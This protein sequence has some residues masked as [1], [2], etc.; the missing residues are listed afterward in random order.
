MTTAEQA[1]ARARLAARHAKVGARMGVVPTSEADPA[2]VL[3]T[4]LRG[5]QGPQGRPGEDGRPGPVGPPG[6]N[7]QDGSDGD[8]GLDGA[9]GP[10]GVGEPGPAGP[11]GK[12]GPKGEKGEKGDKGEDGTNC[13]GIHYDKHGN[14]KESPGLFANIPAPGPPG[15]QGQPGA[16]GTGYVAPVALVE[17]ATVATN[18]L[19]GNRFRVTLTADRTLGA[20]TSPTDGQAAT[21]EV[22]A[23]GADR[24]LTLASG[25]GGFKFGTDITALTAI[26][27]GT[28]DLVGTVY[29]ATANRWWIVAY[30][31]GL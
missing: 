30:L 22:T 20:P 10:P 21:W 25:A 17:A 13:D 28:T 12:R 29:N 5:A 7:G 9:P 3:A 16:P 8:D 27:S 6:R 15:P 31:K 1:A 11:E 14:R 2:E 24:T 18:A 23:S 4:V 19:L 26:V